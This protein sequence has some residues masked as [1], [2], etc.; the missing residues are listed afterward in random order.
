M[1][2]EKMEKVGVCTGTLWKREPKITTP[3]PD[4]GGNR[5]KLGERGRARKDYLLLKKGVAGK[6]KQ[7][8]SKQGSDKNDFIVGH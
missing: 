5:R 3:S 6:F 1:K 8:Q 2:K 7:A 4:L